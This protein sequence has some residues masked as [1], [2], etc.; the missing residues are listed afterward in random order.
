MTTNL[1]EYQRTESPSEW[2][3]VFTFPQHERA[4]IKQLEMRQIESFLPVYEVTH[5]WK[6]RQRVKIA[7]PLFPTYV[8]AKSS[9][10][11]R[12][13]IVRAPGVIRIVGDSRGPIAIPDGEIEFL[14]SELCR[15]KAEPY[16]ELVVGQRVQIKSG[17]MQGVQGT[18]VRKKS[19]L[20]FVITLEL[21]NQHAA[22]EISADDVEPIEAVRMQP[23]S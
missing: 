10:T 15:Q 13:A 22:L 20:R 9:R 8:F 4:V 23:A 3:A 2:Y 1:I 6:N 18:L 7:M 14:N 5:L 12:S 16:S 11:T 19:G 21:I 17:A